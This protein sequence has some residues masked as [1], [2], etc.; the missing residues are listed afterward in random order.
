MSAAPRPL[1][2]VHLKPHADEL[3]SSWLVRLAHGNGLKIQ[4]FCNLVFGSTHQVWNRDIDRL[5]PDWLMDTVSQHTG[6]S[7]REAL[8]TTLRSY[9][10]VL[11]PRF[12][13]S[14]I[15]RWISPLVLYHRTYKGFG[16]Q[17]CPLC[18]AEGAEPYYR[19]HWRV[20]CNIM[21]PTH[22]I[23]LLDRCP[24][25]SGPVAFHRQE[26]GHPK[27]FEPKEM[28]VCFQ[29]GFDLRNADNVRSTGYGQEEWRTL[30]DVSRLV[31]GQATSK[32]FDDGFLPV[33]HQLCK[34]MLMGAE[35]SKL[36]LFI[37]LQTE[38]SPIEIPYRRLS[39]E[40]REAHERKHV[41][42]LATWLLAQPRERISAAHLAGAVRYNRL[43][44]D[45]RDPPDWYDALITALP[46]RLIAADSP[47]R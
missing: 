37:E 31:Q 32:E 8:G 18:L 14:G 7:S 26:L 20:A 4:S 41:L 24:A 25:C 5:A 1:W 36:R 43:T 12:R 6:I 2:P 23:F 44:R 10:G 38:C 22:E 33:L 15:L 34:L 19:K 21:C 17:Y 11:Y 39:I 42:R 3:L 30:L 9:E 40:R 16:L 27:E 35:G 13:A 45:F 28:S 47:P 46:H 29:C